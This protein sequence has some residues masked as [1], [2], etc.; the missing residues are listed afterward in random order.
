MPE[1]STRTTNITF[2]QAFC[3]CYYA[4]Y[5]PWTSFLAFFMILW[6][7]GIAERMYRYYR[8]R[9][10]DLRVPDEEYYLVGNELRK[11]E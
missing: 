2:E 11:S 10:H 7:V 8:G 4:Y 6:G 1:S 3:L 9:N 5:E